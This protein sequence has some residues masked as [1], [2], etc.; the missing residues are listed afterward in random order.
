MCWNRQTVDGSAANCRPWN[1]RAT[2][3]ATL[4][5]R[6]NH[7]AGK[8][9]ALWHE[10]AV[11]PPAL[12]IYR[13]ACGKEGDLTGRSPP[14]SSRRSPA[15]PPAL[16]IR[17]LGRRRPLPPSSRPT[18]PPLGPAPIAWLARHLHGLGGALG[19]A[20]APRPLCHRGV[21][22]RRRSG[23]AGQQWSRARKSCPRSGAFRVRR[24]APFP[25]PMHGFGT[26]TSWRALAYLPLPPL[27][28]PLRSR[29][30]V[31]SPY[32]AELALPAFEG[33]AAST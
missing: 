22:H 19:R 20:A 25:R 4:A 33:C 15:K 7:A 23:P 16:A 17:G 11:G 21:S 32:V 30:L 10:L 26:W 6:K 1:P 27:T 29:A 24:V 31:P 12:A 8:L 13:V 2:G 18:A 28:S 9:A 3:R 5:D 14:P